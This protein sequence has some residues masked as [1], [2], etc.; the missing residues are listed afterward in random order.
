VK[1]FRTIVQALEDRLGIVYEG[2]DQEEVPAEEP[3]GTEAGES[4]Q[5]DDDSEAEEVFIDQSSVMLEEVPESRNTQGALTSL[6]EE[7]STT[8]AQ[9]ADD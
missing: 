4:G 5:E 1:I 6:G 2:T 3:A 9:A 8:V 7:T